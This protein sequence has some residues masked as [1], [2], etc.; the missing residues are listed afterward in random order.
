MPITIL[1]GE[2]MT[3]IKSPS[4]TPD[5]CAVEQRPSTEQDEATG[6]WNL[7]RTFGGTWTALTALSEEIGGIKR[8]VPASGEFYTLTAVYKSLLTAGGGVAPD[9]DDQVVTLYHLGN[10]QETLQIW[11]SP[12]VR[13]ELDG[14]TDPEDRAQ[15]I[16]E[17]TRLASG[18]DYKLETTGT[19]AQTTN[20]LTKT[21]A[22]AAAVAVGFDGTIWDE[23]YKDLAASR[24]D[25]ILW[26]RPVLI[27]RS[28]APHASSVRASYALHNRVLTTAAL[29]GR[30]PDIP[31][32]YAEN[33]ATDCA[34]GYWRAGGLEGTPIDETTASLSQ[35]FTYLGTD[36]PSYFRYGTILTS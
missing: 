11:D 35:Q 32:I 4:Y 17:L 7:T 18:Q 22:R 20:P 13:A 3:I 34:G 21:T 14:I 8:I 27:R 36:L 29:L 2:A 9:P 19:D 16:D 1:T 15:V 5:T 33:I 28:A 23:V 30:F 31:A 10:Q 26:D 24:K 12:L 25:D 6:L